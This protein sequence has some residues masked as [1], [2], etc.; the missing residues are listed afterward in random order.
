[1]PW[2]M[3]VVVAVILFN[4]LADLSCT[5][6]S[7]RGSALTELINTTTVTPTEPEADLGALGLAGEPEG[8]AHESRSPPRGWRG[9]ASAATGWRWSALVVLVI[10]VF[11]CLFPSI[12]ARYGQAERLPVDGPTYIRRAAERRGLVRH[13]RPQPGPLRRSSR[14][15]DLDPHRHLGR[16]DRLRSS[17]R[18]VGG[19]AGYCGGKL[20]DILMRITDLFL[21][22]P[23]LVAL[24]ILRNVA[25]PRCPALETVM[26]DKTSVRSIVIV[27]SAVG[28]MAVARIVRGV[29]LSLKEKEFVE[30]ARPSGP[31]GPRILIRHLHP[32]LRSARS[33]W[34]VTLAVVAAILAES[35]LSF[36]G[37][38]PSAGP[39]DAD[40]GQ[41]DRARR[42]E[43]SAR[44]LVVVLPGLAIVITVLCINYLGDGLRDAVR[45]RQA[46][47]T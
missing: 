19:L 12:P 47:P 11:L 39:G 14:W 36:L 38:G 28:W 22:F 17:G 40:V 42:P 21:A 35:T 43:R 8:L 26:G 20:D 25:R 15:P 6:C 16:R 5:A 29:V 3:F 18:L 33:W 44:L 7:T 41:P 4:L 31:R 27:L 10:V 23:I 46:G 37:Y 13:R 45:P 32:Q 9:A 34:S 2:M 1:M 30:A 24:L